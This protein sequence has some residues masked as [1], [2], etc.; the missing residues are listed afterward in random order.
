MQAAE[1]KVISET[2]LAM[3]G[4][5]KNNLYHYQGNIIIGS[6]ATSVSEEDKDLKITKVVASNKFKKGLDL[7]NIL[8]S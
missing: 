3:K 4:V 8:Q 1:L 5:R 7:F 2:L 6:A